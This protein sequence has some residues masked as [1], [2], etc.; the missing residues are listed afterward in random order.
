MPFK[1]FPLFKK[2]LQINLQRLF[3]FFMG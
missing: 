3:K 2:P 1:I